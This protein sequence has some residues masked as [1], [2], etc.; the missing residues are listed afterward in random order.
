MI[1]REHILPTRIMKT[2][3]SIAGANALLLPAPRQIHIGTPTK[4]KTQISGKGYIVLDFGSE[5]RG[6]IRILCYSANGTKNFASVRLRLG[7]SLGECMAELGEKG[8]CNDHSPRDLQI[9][10]VG[11]SDTVWGNSAFRFARLDFDEGCELTLGAIIAESEILDLPVKYEYKGEDSQLRQIYT[12]A[13]RTIDLCAAGEYVWDGVKRDRLVWIGDM[14]PEMLALTTLY[15]RVPMMDNSINFM[16]ETTPMGNWMCTLATYSAWWLIVLADYY[17]K[18]LCRNLAL[19]NMEYAIKT[20]DRFLECIGEDGE[21][22]E[23]SGSLVDWPTREKPDEN[24]GVRAILTIMAKKAIAFFKAFNQPTHKA[25]LLLER[26]LKQPIKVTHAMQVAGL[27][28]MALGELEQS[29]VDLMERLG[30]KGMSTFMSYYILKAYAHYFGT[31]RAVE[32]MKK[33][34]SGMLS[35]GSTTFWEDFHTDWLEGA[36]RIDEFTPFGKKDIHG[37]YGDYCYKGYRHSLCHAWST[38]ILAFMEE[39]NL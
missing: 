16:R 20:I 6:G 10:I 32:V 4:E 15:G 7:E 24:A 17:E 21:L 33:Y 26:L 1:K 11:L 25:E 23:V 35:V 8:A 2:E 3:G 27:K 12:A 39:N 22:G 36:G 19:E 28:Y 38:G 9:S 5:I 29:D 37:D 31:D 30:E 18:T 13:K 14:H 34:Y